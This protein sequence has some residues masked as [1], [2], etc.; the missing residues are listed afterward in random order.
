MKP[1]IV[2]LILVAA[3]FVRAQE[4]ARDRPRTAAETAVIRGRVLIAGSDSG[5]RRARVSLTSET[6]A[7]QDPIYTDGEG[8]FEFSGVAPGRYV[9][10]AWKSGW[11]EA[12][13]GA[14]TVWDRHV[15]LVATAGTVVDDVQLALQKGAAISG[16]VVDDG[17]EPLVGMSVAVGRVVVRNG[18]PMVE[19]VGVGT[20]T[21][22]L[23]EYRVGGLPAGAFVVSVF[24]FPPP[25]SLPARDSG[26]GPGLFDPMQRPHTVFYPQTLSL[27]QATPIPV[28]VGDEVS[29]VDVTF[30]SM[31][32]SG[33]ISGRIVDPQSRSTNFSI[34]I[35]SDGNGNPAA[36]MGMN[37]SVPQSG[38]FSVPLAP[39]EY[40]VV[41]Q[42]DTGSAMQ[43][44]SVG[45]D[46]ISGIQLVLG[47]RARVSGRVAFEGPT[48]RPTARLMVEA[49]SPDVRLEMMPIR[50]GAERDGQPVMV[51]ANGS[52]TLDGVFGRRELRVNQ[53]PP[54][55]TVKSITAGGHEVL[56]VP[57]DF[58][59]GEDLRDVVITLTDR[60]AELSGRVLD[61]SGTPVSA[62]S[63][64]VF[65]ED[66]RQLPRRAH[67]VKPDQ[68]GRFVVPGLPP[69]IYLVALAADVD[70]TRWSTA[71]YLDPFCAQAARVTLADADKSRSSCGGASLGDARSHADRRSSPSRS[72]QRWRGICPRKASRPH[73]RRNGPARRPGAHRPRPQA[74]PT[75]QPLS[76]AA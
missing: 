65:A 49:S 12:K 17:G 70:D 19:S 8:R 1:T 21:D 53:V 25:S 76:R 59:G 2:L 20:E 40:T 48:P 22:D 27:A 64:L 36:V 6:G 24:G 75:T 45:Q 71:E 51:A 26:P 60:A 37:T 35:V 39:G 55:W 28:R 47:N 32:S 15:S 11:V 63:V 38:E 41:A 30:V 57:I 43:H 46:D 23:G 10:A 31:G 56:D 13:F 66:R 50:A 68:H 52:F 54:G 69:G 34:S 14:R 9:A 4:P 5:V 33:R 3:A 62:A 67:W 18:R 44:L 61:A 16:R 72:S 29:A 58:T 7:P 73:R 42:S 74:P